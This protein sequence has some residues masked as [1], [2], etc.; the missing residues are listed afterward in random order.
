M[1]NLRVNQQRA[2]VVAA[3]TAALRVDQQRAVVVTAQDAALRVVHQRMVLVVAD[4]V[5][6][7]G[8]AQRGWSY[9]IG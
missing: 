4:P 8:S 6:G 3:Q 7:A 2:V 1:A 9:V 5:V